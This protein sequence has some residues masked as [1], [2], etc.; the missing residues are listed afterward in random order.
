MTIVNLEDCRKINVVVDFII[1]HP[2]VT[3]EKVK[4]TFNLSTDE[5]DMISELMMP[6]MR[7]RA[8]ARDF[9]QQ[10]TVLKFQMKDKDTKIAE[11]EEKLKNGEMLNGY[12]EAAAV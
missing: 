7:Q 11:L 4:R 10:I 2:A 5:Y 8:I 6:A 3:V 12:P 9:G 1:T